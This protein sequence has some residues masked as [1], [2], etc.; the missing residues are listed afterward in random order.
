MCIDFERNQIRWAVRSRVAL[1]QTK[2]KAESA[3]AL[4]S[5]SPII[6]TCI[7]HALLA[8]IPAS[9]AYAVVFALRCSERHRTAHE[10]LIL[11][12]NPICFVIW[13]ME[14]TPFEMV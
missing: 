5:R 10:R 12:G 14:I 8:T 1:S 4:L 3:L 2:N 6:I 13:C 11:N 7:R 9:L